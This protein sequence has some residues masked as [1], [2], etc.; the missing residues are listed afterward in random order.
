MKTFQSINPNTGQ[1]LQ[2]YTAETPEQIETK[3]ARAA[4]TQRTWAGQSFAERGDLFRQLAATLRVQQADLAD[5]ITA[6]MGKIKAE[7]MA[8]VEKCAGQC[9]YYA[10]QAERLLHPDIIP[11]DAQ[12]S[13]VVYEPVGVVL[14]IMPWN[15]PLWQ[16]FR[17]AVPALMAGNVTLLKH[18]PNVFGCAL[19]IEQAYR[20]A[21]FPEG[22]FQAIVA[23]TDAVANLLADDR[24]GM[25]TLTGSERAGAS[26]AALA[27]QHIKKSVLELGGSDALIVLADADL[28]RAAQAA[29]QSRMMNAGQV[30]IAAKRF[31]V[32]SSVKAAFT[33]KVKTLVEHLKQG[34]PTEPDTKLGPLARIDLAETLERQVQTAVQEG[35]TLLVGG[36]RHDCHFAPT[37]LD[38]VTPDS[39]VFREETFG[40]VAVIT[41]V[42]DEAEAIRLANQSRYGLS[43]AIWTHDVARAERLSHQLEAGSVFV[44]AVV[45]SDSRLPIGGVKKSGYGRE[46]SEAGIKDFCQSKTIYIG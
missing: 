33:E 4:E 45:R 27:G 46:L 3:L 15:F 44:N 34:D 9:D 26:V 30:C 17:Y 25:V 43:A 11:T 31:L 5:L 41:E 38:N 8:E 37:L 21:G 35:A 13:L 23:D 42:A 39:V 19:A 29:V 32:E 10:E 22:V 6:E 20:T 40:P 1:V 24:V 18:A 12:K 28:D 16:V 7:A 36:T 14:A 2:D